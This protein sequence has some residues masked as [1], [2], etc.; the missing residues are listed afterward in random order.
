MKNT[1]DFFLLGEGMMLLIGGSFT[2]L[3]I[4]SVFQKFREF[5]NCQPGSLSVWS[6]QA[7]HCVISLGG[8]HS[9]QVYLFLL[10]LFIGKRVGVL[11]AEPCCSGEVQSDNCEAVLVP[12]AVTPWTAFIYGKSLALVAEGGV[13]AGLEMGWVSVRGVCAQRKNNLWYYFNCVKKGDFKH[14]SRIS[15]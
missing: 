2:F 7:A 5:R 4:N 13:A 14:S 1:V 10:S 9:Q 11:G 15:S 6:G 8:K 12:G 3:V